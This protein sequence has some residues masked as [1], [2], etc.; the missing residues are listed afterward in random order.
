MKA[1]REGLPVT[2]NGTNRRQFNILSVSDV[3]KIDQ[4]AGCQNR[5]SQKCYICHACEEPVTWTR[6]ENKPVLH[7]ILNDKGNR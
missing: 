7:G 2:I 1:S 5:L 4:P 6:G 3:A